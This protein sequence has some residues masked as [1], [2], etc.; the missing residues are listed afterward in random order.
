MRLS[1]LFLSLL[2]PNQNQNGNI[3]RNS[4]FQ[5]SSQSFEAHVFMGS[6]RPTCN[7]HGNAFC[8]QRFLRNIQGQSWTLMVSLLVLQWAHKRKRTWCTCFTMK[9]FPVG[10]E[11]STATTFGLVFFFACEWKKMERKIQIKSFP[12]LT[13]PGKMENSWQSRRDIRTRC[14]P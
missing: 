13:C 14:C 6:K 2:C 5:N 9:S 4:F 10:L 8:G 11:P 12:A 7:Q 3:A 1:F